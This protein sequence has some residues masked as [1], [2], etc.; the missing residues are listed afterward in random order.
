[1]DEQSTGAEATISDQNELDNLRE[2]IDDPSV[3]KAQLAKEAEARRQI[4][5]RAHNETEKRKKLEAELN[6]LKSQPKETVEEPKNLI[7]EAVDLRLDGYSKQE[8]D[9]ILKN[10]GR[11]AIEDPNS[12]VSLAIKTRKEQT[13]AEIEASKTSRSGGTDT[14]KGYTPEQI[15]N[16]SSKELEKLLP[17]V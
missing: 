9:F 6:A 8:V 14:I 16:M 11:K 4:T 5:A 15:A 3:L 13:Q 17:R 1:M 10:G 12:F 2:G 7:D